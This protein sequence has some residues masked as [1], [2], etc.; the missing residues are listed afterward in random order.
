M[1]I[2]HNTQIGNT[3]DW[4][5][6]VLVDRN[7]RLGALHPNQVLGGARDTS[8]DIDIRLNDLAGLSNLIAVRNPASV[9]DRT[10]CARC[11]VER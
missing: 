7:D 3:K 9:N 11:S 6:R 8:S 5:F 1:N 4:G 10:A 2:A